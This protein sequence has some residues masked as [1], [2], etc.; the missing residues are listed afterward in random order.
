MLS[1]QLN[2]LTLI[3]RLL[4]EDVWTRLTLPI[5]WTLSYAR[6]SPLKA[7]N[8]KTRIGGYFFGSFFMISRDTYETIGTHE[9]VR[10]EIV[11]DVA[12]GRKVKECG[13]KSKVV[14]G[15]NHITAVW[16]RNFSTLWHGLRRLMIPLYLR[17]KDNA[18]LI[19]IATI[20]LLLMP[21]TMFI[22]LMSWYATN[23]L[24]GIFFSNKDSP[25]FLILLTSSILSMVFLLVTS[26]I[27][28]KEVVFQKLIYSLGFPVSGMILSIAFISSI[29]NTR[30]KGAITWHERKYSYSSLD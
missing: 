29:I 23:L 14:R 4:A 22:F 28:S 1:N 20:L 27:Q 13:F 30:R 3:P 11:E 10:T 16:A 25:W 6:Y 8:T 19:T 26:I 2:A 5:L 24:N 18:I 15:E 9:G 12:L 17:E 21:F 7:N